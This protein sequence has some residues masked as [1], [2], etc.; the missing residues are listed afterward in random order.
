[1]T[2]RD[3]QLD[4]RVIIGS[5]QQRLAMRQAQ[6]PNAAVV[7]LADMQRRPH[8]ILGYV[9]NG[10]PITLI[11]QITLAD[12]YDPVGMALRH[13]REGVD[14]VALFTDSRIYSYGM[15][16]LLM[17][18]LGIPYAPVITQD[19]ILNEYHV[20]EARAAGASALVVY[21]SLLEPEDVR[22]VVSVAHRW[23]MTTIVQV[24]STDELAYAAEASPHV[25]GVGLDQRFDR[26]R[27]M[28]VLERLAS[29]IPYNIRWMP[30]GSMSH[31]D[32]VAA[33]VDMGVDALVISDALI[34]PVDR[35]AE[36][37]ELLDRPAE[38]PV[39]LT[40]A[41]EDPDDA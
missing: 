37:C 35:Y 39:D 33:V 27:D 5:K 7:A 36:L 31:L 18:S 8:P 17:V 9:R 30:L 25:I 40:T 1:M 28:A 23:R 15:E 14:A 3:L 26:A 24:S 6:T 12:I 16:D 10:D 34:K 41:F 32:D 13:V 2:T 38:G 20:A 19:Y 29:Q 4:A 21:A 11:S 22:R